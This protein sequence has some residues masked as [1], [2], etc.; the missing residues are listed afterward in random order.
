MAGHGE[1]PEGTPE[2]TP[3]GSADD[4]YR[5]VVF[6]ESFVRAA[7]LQ[8]YS[9]QERMADRGPAVRSVGVLGPGQ[10]YGARNGPRQ[11]LAL[12]VLIALAFGTAVY[13]GFRGPYRAPGPQAVDRLTMTVVPLAPASAVQGGTAAALL[14][15]SPAARYGSGAAGITLPRA[16]DT[17]DY[18][19]SQVVAAL[20]IAKEYL[21]ASSLDPQVLSGA[22][23]ASVRALI[24][25]QETAQFD[26]SFAAPAADGLHD[27]AGWLVSFDPAKVR[28]AGDGVRVHGVLRYRETDDQALEVTSD[29]T[30]VYALRPAGAAATGAA[31]ASTSLF[32]VH[33]ELRF[34][35]DRED[36]AKHRTELVD[37]QVG[38]GPEACSSAVGKS[39]SPLLAGQKAPAGDHAGSLD[40]FTTQDLKGALCGVL[41]T[42]SAAGAGAS[43]SATAPGTPPPAV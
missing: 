9:A 10:A 42:P 5:S 4:E 35:F 17:A 24:A 41:A 31:A 12:F 43:P 2:G 14:A 28:Q 33:R 1:P 25:P 27:P 16:K 8:E 3:D 13:L 15:K 7:R 11:L 34:R 23:R 36:L 19:Q 38:A 40:P 20:T 37:S 26:Y 32:T 29:H 22:E 18:S 6:D 21:V 39:F 30:F